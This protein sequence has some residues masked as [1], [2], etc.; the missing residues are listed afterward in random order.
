M[1]HSVQV[2]SILVAAGA[3]FFAVPLGG[4]IHEGVKFTN[5]DKRTLP[6]KFG[7]L[8]ESL[9]LGEPFTL[10]AD[11]YYACGHMAMRLLKCGCHLLSRVRCT[12]VAF[13]PPPP[14][15]QTARGR[16]RPRVTG[17]YK[18]VSS[19]RASCSIWPSPARAWSGPLSDLGCAPYALASLPRSS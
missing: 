17:I 12:A 10:V 1:G 13:L 4:R 8:I 16:G 9:D 19:L 7:D 6:G 11:A 2:I 18:S 5:R 14:V 3:S 15:D